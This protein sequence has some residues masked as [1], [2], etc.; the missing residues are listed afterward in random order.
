MIGGEDC[1]DDNHI[2]MLERHND[3]TVCT[4]DADGDGA[5]RIAIWL[6]WLVNTNYYCDFVICRMGEWDRTLC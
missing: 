2:L 5:L 6:V 3:P 4:Q 1:N